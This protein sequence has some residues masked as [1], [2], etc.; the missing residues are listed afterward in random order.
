VIIALRASSCVPCGTQIDRDGGGEVDEAE[1]VE[2]I[3]L[4]VQSAQKDD[5]DDAEATKNTD[6]NTG[7][8]G[9]QPKPAAPDES[10]EANGAADAS[11]VARDGDGSARADPPDRTAEPA[12][13]AEAGRPPLLARVSSLEQQC[14]ACG[15]ALPASLRFCLFCGEKLEH[16]QVQSEPPTRTESC[17]RTWLAMLHRLTLLSRFRRDRS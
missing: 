12:P 16:S 2:A 3:I 9:L 10:A 4:A 7:K 17:R 8:A 5:G 15:K 11:P 14:R 1:F 6:L 13:P